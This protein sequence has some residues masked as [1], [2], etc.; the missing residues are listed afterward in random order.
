MASHCD[1]TMNISGIEIHSGKPDFEY[2]AIRR[3]EAKAE[4]RTLMS[5]PPTNADVD[6]QLRQLAAK[7]GADAIIEVEYHRG[8]SMTSWQSLKGTGLAVKRIAD[9]KTCPVCAE[10]IKKAAVK[11]RFCGS[12]LDFVSSAEPFVQTQSNGIL[13]KK[14]DL[15]ASPRTPRP[16]RLPDEPLKSTDNSQVGFIIVVIVMVVLFLATVL[17]GG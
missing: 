10:T 11:C 9:T 5:R 2:S 14:R 15:I 3:L 4:G 6:L 17:S 13:E 8:V 1:G 16:H 7:V 12:G